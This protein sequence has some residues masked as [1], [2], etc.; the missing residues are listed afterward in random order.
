[1]FTKKIQTTE[2]RYCVECIYYKDNKCHNRK[3]KTLFK[4]YISNSDVKNCPFF[5]EIFK[6]FS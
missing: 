2:D 3:N 1:M 6:I 4:Q 5:V